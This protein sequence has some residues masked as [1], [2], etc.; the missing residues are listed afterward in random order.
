M[1]TTYLKKEPGNNANW[2]RGGILADG[3]L[4]AVDPVGP[5]VFSETVGGSPKAVFDLPFSFTFDFRP[6]ELVG[7]ITV[8]LNGQLQHRNIP[9][10]GAGVPG[11]SGTRQYS[12]IESAPASGVSSRIEFNSTLPLGT[13]VSFMGFF[14]PFNIS[15]VDSAAI[16]A[17]TASI[18]TNLQNQVTTLSVVNGGTIAV[19]PHPS[20]IV[21]PLNVTVYKLTG[22]VWLKTDSDISVEANTALT[23]TTVKNV[24][25]GTLDFKVIWA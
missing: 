22:G 14:A 11:A 1:T 19:I 24:S 7:Q 12:E 20:G 5:L 4:P 13:E 10:S 23:S 21:R 2:K 3:G 16:A 18:L 9:Q 15:A 17:N 25:A 8:W 6:G